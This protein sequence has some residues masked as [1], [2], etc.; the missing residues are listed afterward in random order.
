M[1]NYQNFTSLLSPGDLI[2][3]RDRRVIS[4]SFPYWNLQNRTQVLSTA[5]YPD[6]VE[7]LRSRRVEMPT[8]TQLSGTVSTS[9]N[10]TTI[11]FT[12]SQTLTIRSWVYFHTAGIFAQIT[13]GS[14]TSYTI[15]VAVTLSSQSVS[16]IDFDNYVSSFNGTWAGTT[17]TL[18]DTAQNRV[19]IQALSEDHIMG[20]NSF[21]DWMILR[22]GTTDI[23]IT[24]ANFNPAN[25]TLTVASGT[26]TGTS[27]ELYPFRT[28]TSTQAVHKQ[29][30]DVHFGVGGLEIVSGLRRG[31]KM[32]PIT[33]GFGNLMHG[34]GA[35][36]YANGTFA[37]NSGSDTGNGGA[38][39]GN[40]NQFTFNSALQTRTD[41]FTQPRT[42]GIYAYEF[43]G[44]II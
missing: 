5:N 12:T 35:G 37:L 21:S 20:A 18:N 17:F 24:G 7:Y 42:L 44:R 3:R 27:I 8:F 36:A 41:Q 29:V 10:S 40:V 23:N 43:V 2:F 19:L 39:G 11:T 31:D 33:G 9:G 14:G 38:F 15:A 32:Q 1:S 34:A 25:R 26:P 16:V 22:W 30:L 6:Y 4:S 28:T 13:G